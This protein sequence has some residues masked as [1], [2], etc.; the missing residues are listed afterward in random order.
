MR[1]VNSELKSE[2]VLPRWGS[3][4]FVP[5]VGMAMGRL[6]PRCSAMLHSQAGHALRSIQAARASSEALTATQGGGQRPS[7]RLAML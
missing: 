2:G 5:G 4:V 6:S 7:A 1:P 3:A